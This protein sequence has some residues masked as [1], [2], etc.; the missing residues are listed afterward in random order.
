MH[1]RTRDRWKLLGLGLILLL[2]YAGFVRWFYHVA[3]STGGVHH[4][5]PPFV[6]DG[7]LDRTNRF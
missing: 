1:S 7:S 2:L 6:K 5:D 3:S 4:H